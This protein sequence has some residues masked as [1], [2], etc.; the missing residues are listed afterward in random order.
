M[1]LG[2]CWHIDFAEVKFVLGYLFD[3]DSKMV[4]VLG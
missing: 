4:T 1:H 3:T 2:S